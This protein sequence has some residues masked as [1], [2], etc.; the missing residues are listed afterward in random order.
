MMSTQWKLENIFPATT[1]LQLFLIQFAPT[2]SAAAV[3]ASH[4][5]DTA[6]IEVDE[7]DETATG[8]A[9]STATKLEAFCS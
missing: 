6:V 2:T 3:G 7:T 8:L 9:V 4:L 1:S 5:E